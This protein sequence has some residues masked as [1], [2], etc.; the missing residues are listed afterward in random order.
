M[1]PSGSNLQNL[2]LPITPNGVVYGAIDRA[3]IAGATLRMLSASGAAALPSACFDDP[4]QQGQVTRGDGYYKF[5]LNF[6]DAACPSGGSYLIE[7]VAPGAALQRRL[8]AADSADLR[9][10]RRRRSR[11]RPVRA[12]PTT[13]CRPR[14]TSARRRPPS[15]RRRRRC[16]ARTPGT[17]YYVHLTARLDAA[18]PGTSQIFNNHIPLDPV[19]DGAVAITKTTPSMNVSR[20]QLVPYEITLSNTLGAELQDVAIVDRFPAGFR[21]VEGSARIDG[22]PTEPTINGRELVWSN[23]GVAG[24]GP[25]DPAAPARGRRRRHRGRVREPRPGA[26][27]SLT[28]TAAVGRGHAPRCAWSRTRPSTAPT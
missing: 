1:V 25:A 17:N 27:S 13:R 11:S 20:G 22:V 14:S 10:P 9:T 8:L 3:P 19:L 21:Y 12:A 4:V 28:G 7:V 18:S 26:S 16:R 23:L 24:L 6:S 15:S 2:N 5:D